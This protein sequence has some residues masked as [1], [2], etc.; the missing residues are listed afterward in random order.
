MLLLWMPKFPAEHAAIHLRNLLL[1]MLMMLK[2]RHNPWN[3]M[4]SRESSFNWFQSVAFK[5]FWNE[6]K[7][8]S[9]F[10]Y[11][12]LFYFSEFSS[13]DICSSF[14][15]FIKRLFAIQK[16]FP[17]ISKRRCLHARLLW[18]TN[19]II[20]REVFDL[21]RGIADN[22]LWFRRPSPAPFISTDD[23]TR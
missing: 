1:M 12:L 13:F 22:R 23:P 2:I 20:Y 4:R 11:F 6:K 10:L 9:F 5:Y 19:N 16:Y 7:T 15:L 3:L 21:S 18:R 14:T 8:F 17:R